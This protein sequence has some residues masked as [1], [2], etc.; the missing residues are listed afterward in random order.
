MRTR[1]DPWVTIPSRRGWQLTPVFSPAEF[2]G[3][4]N[5][6]GYS[7]S[8][9]TTE[10]LTLS[11]HFFFSKGENIPGVGA[12]WPNTLCRIVIGMKVCEAGAEWGRE[13]GGKPSQTLWGPVGHVQGSLT[14]NS[15]AAGT[16]KGLRQREH[17]LCP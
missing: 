13:E 3:Q 4:R 12:T 11:L 2:H 9:H 7:P 8:D 15:K 1:F 16:I 6:V 5:L 10:R 17:K 14:F